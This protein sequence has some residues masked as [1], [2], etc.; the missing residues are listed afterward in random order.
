MA[1]LCLRYF[2]YSKIPK[3]H[4]FFQTPFSITILIY[5]F[6]PPVIWVRVHPLAPEEPLSLVLQ[7]AWFS[8]SIIHVLACYRYTPFNPDSWYT[9]IFA[10]AGRCAGPSSIKCCVPTTGAITTVPPSSGGR[11]FIVK[12]YVITLRLCI[13][14]EHY[15]SV[16][17]RLLIFYF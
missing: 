2:W 6:R 3:S 16:V 4:I 9:V 17:C 12:V 7:W 1:E 13:S 11:Y 14:I 5:F 15:I 10:H 8:F